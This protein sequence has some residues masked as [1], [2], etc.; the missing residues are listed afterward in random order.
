MQTMSRR[1]PTEYGIQLRE[2]QKAR[3]TYGILETQFRRYY[4]EAARGKLSKGERFLQ[5]LELRMDSVV[6]RMGYALSRQQ[7]RQ[8]I[9]HGHF[10]L[11]GRKHTIP[12]AS[13]KPGDSVA[14]REK[15]QNLDC[16]KNALDRAEAMGRPDWLAVKPEDFTGSV[17]AIPERDQIESTVNEQLIVEFYSR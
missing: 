3:R 14:V 13:L 12:S 1:R 11:N 15:S 10:M 17:N 6:Y 9:T 8:L 2:K 5:L 4:R 7:A 16:V